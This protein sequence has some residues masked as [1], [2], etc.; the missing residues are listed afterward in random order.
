[1]QLLF[2]L[3]DKPA[4]CARAWAIIQMVPTSQSMARDMGALYERGAGSGK[5]D[6]DDEHED[7]GGKHSENDGPQ[8]WYQILGDH[9]P[10][11]RRVYV[12]QMVEAALLPA[13]AGSGAVSGGL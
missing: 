3:L 2:S 10:F 12:C 11:W 5:D 9:E 6:D 13:S 4:V 7:G 1:M 8:S